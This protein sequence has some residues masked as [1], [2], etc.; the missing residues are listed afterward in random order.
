MR[1]G[2]VVLKGRD[3]L[4]ERRGLN[5]RKW[6]L[7]IVLPLLRRLPLPRASRMIAGIGRIEYALF[8]ELRAAFEKETSRLVGVPVRVTGTIDLRVL[9]TPSILLRGVEIGEGAAEGRLRARELGIEFGLGALARG[10]WRAVEMRLVGPD[11]KFGLDQRGRIDWPSVLD[12][13]SAIIR[14]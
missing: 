4:M 3:A 14:A 9:P 2:P 8:P 11:M 6:F 7:G 10:Q 13:C 5:I 12:I 1:C